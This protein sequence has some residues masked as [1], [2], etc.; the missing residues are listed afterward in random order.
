MGALKPIVVVIEDNAKLLR[1]LRRSLQ[2]SGFEVRGADSGQAGLTVIKHSKP[3]LI[4][5]DLGLREVD[6]LEIMRKLREWWSSKP[7]I[8]LSERTSEVDKVAAL[9]LG[10]DDYVAKPFGLSE[11][12]A[13][14][15]AV[16]RRASRHPQS[17]D[18]PEFRSHGVTVDMLNRRV[19]RDGS[20]I[21]LTPSE[22]RVLSI[23]V[24]SCGL[25]V[26]A[27]TLINELWGP[28]CPPTNR[29][30]LRTYVASLRKKLEQ[31]PA[32]PALLLTEPGIGYRIALDR[33]AANN[34]LLEGD[35]KAPRPERSLS[36][37]AAR[38]GLICTKRAP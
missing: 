7:M 15:R 4:L 6:G 38:D 35:R 37:P 23:L 8:V 20:V 31:D 1:L 36:L 12:L 27:D 24:R 13:R 11:L 32:A 16:M 33:P 9:D 25:L 10:A 18:A 30:C 29:S 28:T 34:N 19:S 26:T 21:R 14:V 17:G 3:D 5:L 2:R 22:F